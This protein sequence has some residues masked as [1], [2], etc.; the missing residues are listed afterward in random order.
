MSKNKSNN[1]EDNS[2]TESDKE[3]IEEDKRTIATAHQ[4]QI[5]KEFV[6]KIKKFIKIDDIIRDE[7]KEYREKMNTL[8][9][10][11]TDLE[12]FIIRYLERV[13]EDLINIGNDKLSKVE[14]TRTKSLKKE[15]IQESIYEQLRKENILDEEAAKIMALKTF[16]LM[17]SKREKVVST[18]LRR[19]RPRK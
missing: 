10:Q 5:S 15:H 17:E 11:K 7:T 6:Q 18:K 2:F 4:E 1:S 8:K 9:E 12:L 19:I 3:D 14:S 16:E 13:N